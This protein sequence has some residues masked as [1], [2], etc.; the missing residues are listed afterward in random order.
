MGVLRQGGNAVD[1]AVAGAFAAF[2]AEPLLASPGGAGMLTLAKPGEPPAV[3]DFFPSFP[4][5]R[6]EARDFFEVDVDFG[7]AI[8]RFHVGRAS[9]APPLALP[10]LIEAATRFGSLP[11]ANLVA[12]AIRMAREGV[13]LGVEGAGV[14]ALLWAIQELSRDAVALA[15]GARPS[16]GSVLKNLELAA[17]LEELGDTSRV[18]ERFTRALI[19]ELGPEAGGLLSIAD[20]EGAAPTV[21]APREIR[22]GDWTIL[23]SPRIGGALVGVILE[24]LFLREPHADEVAETLR[25]A[26]ASRA[27][28]DA[29][30]TLSGRGSTTHLSTIDALGGIASVT[31]TNGEGC[32]HVLSG[33]GVQVN[34]FL[35]EEDLNPAGF[36][37]HRPGTPL[38]TMIAP[39]IGLLHGAPVLGS[40][41]GGSNRIRS[42]VSQV[43]YRVM[44]GEPVE[45]AVIAPRIHAESDDA[46]IELAERDHPEAIVRALEARFGRVHAFPNRAFYFGGANT[47]MVDAEG[48]THAAGDP[49]R[50][51]CVAYA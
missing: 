33:T 37:V 3:V 39:T 48:H 9:A 41:S 14:F 16:A 51:G 45:H 23:T 34:N 25:F 7:S 32:G 31:L 2:V 17:L 26:L 1:A 28:H 22:V 42:V 15:G 18:P 11:L 12:P 50:G 49:R 38:P 35:G 47:V 5:G 27:G 36:H 24:Q 10:G 20:I 6:P 4:S 30:T 21:V 46:W 40:G 8:Q 43:L 13:V 19:E 44:R 29:R